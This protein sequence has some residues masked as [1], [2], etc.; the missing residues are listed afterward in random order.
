VQKTRRLRHQA[1]FAAVALIWAQ[2]A[3]V[4]FAEPASEEAPALR[5]ST[6]VDAQPKRQS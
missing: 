1:R 3:L 5:L 2:A 6:L 4:V